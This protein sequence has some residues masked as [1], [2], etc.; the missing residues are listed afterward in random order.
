[1]TDLPS[2]EDLLTVLAARLGKSQRRGVPL[3]IAGLLLIVVGLSVLTVQL[4]RMR[5]AAVVEAEAATKGFNDSARTLAEARA[6]LAAGNTAKLGELLDIAV[7][8]AEANAQSAALP[9][10]SPA[11]IIVPQVTA[12]S[13]P[14]TFV[15][16]AASEAFTQAVFIQFAGLIQR[17]DVAA[18]NRSLR[19]AGWNMQGTDGERIGTAAGLNEVRFSAEADRPA[20]EALARALTAA[21]LGNKDVVARHVRIIKPGTLEAWI[22][23][24]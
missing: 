18:V 14:P 8:E 3:L 7:M 13:T 10:A 19:D 9:A 15:A 21:K 24:T 2:Q 1:M 12:A 17:A 4:N 22:S 11:E 23:K 6:A 5:E 20:A 16:T